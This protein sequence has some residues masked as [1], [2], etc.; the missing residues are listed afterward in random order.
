[1][2]KIT[3]FDTSKELAHDLAEELLRLSLMGTQKHIAFSG[4]ST[5]VL[6]FKLLSEEP[7]PNKILWGNLHFWW[8]D[9]RCVPAESEESNYG[10]FKRT[11]A[12]AIGLFE[13]NIHPVI[14]DDDAHSALEVYAEKLRTEVPHVDKKPCF[15]L[16]VLGMGDDGHTASLFKENKEN[17]IVELA[18]AALVK[19]PQSGQQRVTLTMPVINNSRHIIFMITGA[20]KAK[21]LDAIL[22]EDDVSFP[23]GQ[24]KPQLGVLQWF[25]DEAAFGKEES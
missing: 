4:G 13:T 19:H 3:V 22:R 23:A 16:M 24:V 11:L 10:V 2:S 1:M 20:N 5:P 6:L 25:V 18:D 9:E 14:G 12:D 8:V 21:V 7:Y 17:H 15:D